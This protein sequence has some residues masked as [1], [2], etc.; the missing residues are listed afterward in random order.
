MCE[1]NN[2]L[3]ASFSRWEPRFQWCLG[4]WTEHFEFPSPRDV[5]KNR[6]IS[7]RW[8]KHIAAIALN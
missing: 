3:Y 2:K 5:P 7:D 1:E 4:F 6:D 8:V